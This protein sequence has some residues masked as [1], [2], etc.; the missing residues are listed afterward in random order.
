[1]F[2]MMVATAAGETR[3]APRSRK[4]WCWRSK[5]SLPPAPVAMTAPTR[6]RSPATSSAASARAS[7]PAATASWLTRSIRRAARD[8]MWSA[9]AKPFTSQA[10]RHA[11][12]VAS[13]CVIGP[14][15][16]RPSRAARQVSSVSRP[17]GLTR[18]MPV[19]TT[20]R[21]AGPLAPLPFMPTA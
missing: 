20:R 18:P 4:S 8:S 19:I 21:P 7:R 9:G 15:P 17:S 13:K 11:C 12:R 14:A 5:V 16:D 10:M 3:S 2:T 1:M 6:S